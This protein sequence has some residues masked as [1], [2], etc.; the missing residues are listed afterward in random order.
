M[1]Q[2]AD[3]GLVDPGLLHELVDLLLTFRKA[4]RMRRRVGSASASK[5]SS[6][7]AMYMYQCACIPS[8]PL[9]IDVLFE[10]RQEAL[11]EEPK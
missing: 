4:S 10:L 6:G 8:L 3:P 1:P 5:T 11:D 2:A 9:T 7:I